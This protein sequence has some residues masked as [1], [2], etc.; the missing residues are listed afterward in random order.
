MAT[1]VLAAQMT[2]VPVKMDPQLDQQTG[3]NLSPL[4]HNQS[5]DN[6]NGAGTVPD[7]EVSAIYIDI[8]VKNMFYWYSVVK[9]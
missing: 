9:W 5:M 4:S 1:Q 6:L 2:G 8:H 3:G 7:D